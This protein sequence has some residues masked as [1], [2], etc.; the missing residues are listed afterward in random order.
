MTKSVPTGGFKSALQFPLNSINFIFVYIYLCFIAIRE[1]ASDN[2][3]NEAI[4]GEC[5][6]TSGGKLFYNLIFWIPCAAWGLS[7]IITCNIRIYT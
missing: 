1:G 4:G 5:T 7:V 6:C 2:I 3:R